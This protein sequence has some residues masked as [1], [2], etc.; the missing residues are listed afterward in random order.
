MEKE[1][2]TRLGEVERRLGVLWREAGLHPVPPLTQRVSTLTAQIERV[3][4]KL[5]AIS[6]ILGC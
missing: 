5:V 4:G 3:E 2:E 6:K 1:I